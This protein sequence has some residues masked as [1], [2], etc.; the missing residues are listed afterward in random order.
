[1]IRVTLLSAYLA[2][3]QGP[4]EPRASKMSQVLSP[5]KTAIGAVAG[6]SNTGLTLRHWWMPRFATELGLYSNFGD[7]FGIYSVAAQ[8]LYSLTEVAEA[9][10]YIHAPMRWVY[11]REPTERESNFGPD[12]WVRR[13]HKLRM[14]LGLGL[15]ARLRPNL[16]MMMELPIVVQL[17]DISVRN[18]V[19]DDIPRTRVFPAPNVGFYVYFR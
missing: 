1:M 11:L 2:C 6:W 16:A 9:N 13:V 15:E 17:S 18:T 14:G 8:L 4:E 5:S 10:L 7:R 19:E 12:P 3:A